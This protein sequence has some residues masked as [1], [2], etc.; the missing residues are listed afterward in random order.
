M[1]DFFTEEMA[2]RYDERN[3]KLTAI[4]EAMHFLIRLVL[5][6]L[7]SRSR[8]LCVGAGTGAE[9]IA[10][11][12]SFPE[13][14]FVALDPSLSM[15]NVCRRRMGSEGAAD[16][17]E[18]VHGYVQDLPAHGD[19]DAVLSIL[20]AHF[21]KREERLDFF[22][23]IA[24]HLKSDGWFVNTEISFDLDS[25]EFPAMLQNWEKVQQLMG[26]TPET[27]ALLPK[28]LRE[29][30]TVLPPGEAEDLMRQGGIDSP[31]RFFQ[32]FMICGW[33]GRKQRDT[34]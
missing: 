8:I 22:R 24:R 25:P 34:C 15:L 10:L 7:P 1:T 28:Q 6:N 19:F 5:R 23:N 21:I 26:A 4:S 12:R 30:L 9:I 18:F 3:S 29:M 2:Q 17:C 20:V 31:I 11:S 27:L 14:N 13:W 32:A 16:R 33:H